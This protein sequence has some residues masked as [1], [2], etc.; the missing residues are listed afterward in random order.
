MAI[1]WFSGGP[2]PGRLMLSLLGCLIV[3]AVV[4]VE[5]GMWPPIAGVFSVGSHG[6][7]RACGLVA[8]AARWLKSVLGPFGLG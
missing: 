2:S 7:L 4:S 3:S 8:E 1:A 5:G 6:L